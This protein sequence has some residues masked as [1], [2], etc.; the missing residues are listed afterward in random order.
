VTLARLR[1]V[2]RLAAREKAKTQGLT[3]SDA[4]IAEIKAL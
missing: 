3:I 4:L 2:R 1:G